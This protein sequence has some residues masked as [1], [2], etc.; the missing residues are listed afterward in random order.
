M[1][2]IWWLTHRPAKIPSARQSRNDSPDPL[3]T[4]RNAWGRIR[5]EVLIIGRE[6]T[7]RGRPTTKVDVILNRLQSEGKMSDDLAAFVRRLKR[8]QEDYGKGREPATA[9]AA[10]IFSAKAD[11]AVEELASLRKLLAGSKSA[12]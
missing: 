6:H 2:L 12:R 8:E 9:E 11:E 5:K 10:H 3:E 4:I 1:V 7:V